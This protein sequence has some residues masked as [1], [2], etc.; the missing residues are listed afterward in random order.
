MTHETK[1]F[2]QPVYNYSK[3]KIQYAE[4]LV[5]EYMGISNVPDILDFVEKNKIEEEFDLDILKGTLDIMTNEPPLDYPI[6]VNLCSKTVEKD[7]SADK[8]ISMINEYN[9]DKDSIILEINEETKFDNEN[10]I[11]NLDKL[12]KAGFKLALDDFG[13]GK[14]TMMSFILNEFDII[15]IDK[16]FIT[17]SKYALKKEVLKVIVDMCNKLGYDMIVEGVETDQQLAYIQSVGLDSV[18]GFLYAKPTC[19][20][21]YMKNNVENKEGEK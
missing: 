18:Q 14:T 16:C 17:D 10:V 1:L 5:R 9:V 4:V 21:D 19:F 20:I 11:K 3:E 12:H 7:G 6:S 15:K 2:I 8:V 13:T